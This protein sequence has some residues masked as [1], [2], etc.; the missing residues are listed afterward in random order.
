MLWLQKTV[1]TEVSVEGV[2]LHSGAKSHMT[3]A[4]APINTGL[5]FVVPAADGDLEIPALVEYVS[6][7]QDLVRAT[8]LAKDGIT[9][10]TVEHVLSALA[11]IGRASCRERV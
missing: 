1:K 11:E 6:D 9:I 5:V 10:H 2:G 8:T 3:F 7:Q 4:P